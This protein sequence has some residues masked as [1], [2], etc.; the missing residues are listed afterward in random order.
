M[1]PELQSPQS[2]PDL[3]L[4]PEL[5]LELILEMKL[6]PERE[7]ELEPELKLA[8]APEVESLP[9]AKGPFLDHQSLV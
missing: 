7:P 3:I 8:S 1:A 2:I 9:L 4:E 5:E 6:E